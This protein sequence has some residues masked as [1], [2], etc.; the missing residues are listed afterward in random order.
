MDPIALFAGAGT[1]AVMAVPLSTLLAAAADGAEPSPDAPSARAH[2]PTPAQ[3][4]GGSAIAVLAQPQS[5]LLKEGEPALFRAVRV[6]GGEPTALRYQWRRNGIDIAG[7]HK[8]WLGLDRVALVD[9]GSRYTVVV[10]TGTAASEKQTLR[11]AGRQRLDCAEPQRQNTVSVG[12]MS[13]QRGMRDGA[14]LHR[15]G[16]AAREHAIAGL[17]RRFQTESTRRKNEQAARV[18]RHPCKGVAS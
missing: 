10:S 15:R 7:A 17:A 4:D 8:P 9:D 1:R 12:L 14:A 16:A 5:L 18:H 11:A 13:G 6:R 2:E 3:P